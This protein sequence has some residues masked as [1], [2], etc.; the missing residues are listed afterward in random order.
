MYILT[1]KS[2]NGDNTIYADEL[3]DGTDGNYR[4]YTTT[5]VE[6]GFVVSATFDNSKV[7]CTI[8]NADGG[9]I[10]FDGVEDAS[11]NFLPGDY[12]NLIITPDTSK[13]LKTLSIG[14]KTYTLSELTEDSNFEDK[15]NGSYTYKFKM[16]NDPLTVTASYDQA[17]K[18][19][20]DN[21]YNAY[22]EI[23]TNIKGDYALEGDDVTITV[24][25]TNSDSILKAIKIDNDT[26]KDLSKNTAKGGEY[27]YEFKMPNKDITVSIEVENPGN[28]KIDKL[29]GG[30]IN[31]SCEKAYPG[32]KVTLT[33]T[34]NSKKYLKSLSVN[35]TPI[36]Q[37][38]INYIKG[39]AI[40][41]NV[42][43]FDV[44]MVKDGLNIAA[45]FTDNRKEALTRVYEVN[46]IN[47]L[48]AFRNNVNKDS[49]I[50]EGATIKLM[51]NIDLENKEW[52]PIDFYYGR[53]G[54]NN[55]LGESL[56]GFTFDGNNKT[57]SNLKVNKV[58]VDNSDTGKFVGFFG[59][60]DYSEIKNLKIV[61]ANITGINQVGVIC[62]AMLYGKGINGCSVE[63]A[64]VKADP[65][66]KDSGGEY[67]GDK[68]GA[69]AGYCCP[70]GTTN[71][72]NNTV[73]D[74]ELS[75]YRDMGAVI[76]CFAEGN[77]VTLDNTTLSG[78]IN[79]IV[80]NSIDDATNKGSKGN[81]I[82]ESKFNIGDLWGR[83]A[84]ATKI[85]ETNINKNGATITKKFSFKGFDHV[86]G[87]K[88]YNIST[89]DG[90]FYFA[91]HAEE[92][93]DVT[94]NITNDIDL[95][96]KDWEPI[97]FMVDQGL[98]ING[99]N[100]S[101]K[102]MT[103]NKDT[104]TDY[105]P[106]DNVGFFGYV[107]SSN[108]K[109]QNLTFENPIVKAKGKFV[110]TV[111]GSC[112]GTITLDN[113][114]IIGS[115]VLTEDFLKSDGV[116][117]E[118]SIRVGGMIGRIMNEFA[119]NDKNHVTLKNCDVDKL[120][121][122]GYHNVGGM[123][124]T[125]NITEKQSGGETITWSEVKT[126]NCTLSNSTITYR[127]NSSDENKGGFLFGANNV[128]TEYMPLSGFT[129]T[130]NNQVIKKP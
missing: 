9:T 36:T 48:E 42:L 76:G 86:F 99:N 35:G 85:T 92:F 129:C 63:K 59:H 3:L 8:D 64:N 46:N 54:T 55:S 74:V 51:N 89:A 114:D 97:T 107:Q 62:G 123:I 47:D 37:T 130:N 14:S 109:I 24:K 12:V 120:T 73:K 10:K 2:K 68:V 94:I 111:I 69:I 17:Y 34:P 5:M 61:N 1:L 125:C 79:F 78:Y 29:S 106:N 15:N 81:G 90:L 16:T 88:E 101:I 65:S 126:E 4:Y 118:R 43:T 38:E 115:Q 116:N 32:S 49:L 119:F 117:Y 53:V 13:K 7:A 82:D 102:N 26:V 112:T 30:E 60:A 41:S 113:V 110:G 95:A 83:N 50:Y 52:E 100:H 40:D 84:A 103:I 56:V 67:N 91:K 104:V 39:K 108:F 72:S 77:E 96:G 93:K 11:K 70:S 122:N 25:V 57:I 87:T 28:V 58:G 20:K 66:I 75:G 27:T 128:Y 80:D 121:I 105:V 22:A 31:A 45:E 6:G 124:G 98:T 18:I 127:V 23:T 19:A 21:T 33:I 71:F 44:E